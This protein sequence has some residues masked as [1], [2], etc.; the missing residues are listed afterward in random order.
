MPSP[1][2]PSPPP[3][4]DNANAD[5]LI[6]SAVKGGVRLEGDSSEIKKSVVSKIVGYRGDVEKRS[7]MRHVDMKYI[8]APLSRR[9]CFP[10]SDIR[11]DHALKMDLSSRTRLLGRRLDD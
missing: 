2:S 6:N 1:P 9:Q 11:S 8:V 5:A 10:L 7:K 4:L 3:P